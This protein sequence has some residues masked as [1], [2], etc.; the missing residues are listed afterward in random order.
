[1]VAYYKIACLSRGLVIFHCLYVHLKYTRD[2]ISPSKLAIFSFLL[3]Y[4]NSGYPD[5]CE[6]LFLCGL[7]V[8]FIIIIVN[9][10]FLYIFLE[11]C[12]F[13][14]LSIFQVGLFVV[15]IFFINSDS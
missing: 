8:H 6:V 7:T 2:P 3:Y 14:V 11:K 12:P 1:M 4:F 13:E 15:E 5:G 10:S 9:I